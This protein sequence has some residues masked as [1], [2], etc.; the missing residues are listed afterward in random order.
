MEMTQLNH[1]TLVDSFNK[2]DSVI[3]ELANSY[4]VD[5]IDASKYF[6]GKSELFTDHVHTTKLGSKL[7]AE[8]LTNSLNIIFREK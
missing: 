5:I 4:G 3:F 2:C 8:K 6:T 1:D 7:I